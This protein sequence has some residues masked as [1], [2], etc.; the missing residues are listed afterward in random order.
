MR[1]IAFCFREIFF[2]Q[3]FV[4]FVLFWNIQ[5]LGLAFSALLCSFVTLYN[6]MVV[7]VCA[8]QPQNLDILSFGCQTLQFTMV[9]S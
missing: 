3:F 6:N 1:Q 5:I 7:I 4:C 8:H 2:Y 9:L